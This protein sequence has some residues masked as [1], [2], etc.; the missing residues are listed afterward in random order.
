[1][2]CKSIL[3]KKIPLNFI[4]T[5]TKKQLH[6]IKLRKKKNET[7]FCKCSQKK[8]KKKKSD[9]QRNTHYHSIVKKKPAGYMCGLYSIMI[10]FFEF[11]N[12]TT[13]K[14][15]KLSIRKEN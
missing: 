2:N 8:V 12:A 5:S 4:A 6:E 10:I 9:T 7:N 14:N 15:P 1:M 11:C 13:K 3:K